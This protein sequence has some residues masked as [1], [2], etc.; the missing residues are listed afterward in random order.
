MY[1]KTSL[2]RE[3]PKNYHMAGTTTSITELLAVSPP[4][5]LYIKDGAAQ[6]VGQ[7]P[8]I[9]LSVNIGDDGGDAWGLTIENDIVSVAPQ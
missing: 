7:L 9:S 8:Q 1:L 2:Q 6:Q 5:Y 3:K 4:I